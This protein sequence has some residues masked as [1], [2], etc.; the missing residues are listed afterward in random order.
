MNFTIYGVNSNNKG[1]ELM[2]YS[3]KQKIQD[4]DRSNTL[5]TNVK[6]GSLEQGKQVTINYLPTRK[7]QKLAANLIPKTVRKK[8]GIT[9]E[10]EVDAVLDASG[11]A[12]S[13]QW[14]AGKTEH[15]AD[16]YSRWKSQGKKIVLL[17]Q[18][19]GPFTSKRIQDAFSQ[20]LNNVDLVFA[21][22]EVSYE[23]I[24]QLSVPMEQV[25]IAPDFTNLVQ[26]IEPS[27]I[28]DLIG[29]PCIIPNIRMTDK[30][31]P[32]LSR[33]YFSFL[34]SSIEYLLDKGLEPFILLHQLTDFELGSQLQ[35]QVSRTVP[36]IKED[37]PLYIKGILGKCYLVIS[38]RFH[39]L[40]SALSQGVPCVGTGWSHKYKML[41]KTYNCSDLL[42]NLENN[43]DENLSKL[44]AIIYEPTRTQVI[45]AIA[46]AAKQQ[47]VSSQQMWADVE[48]LL[49]NN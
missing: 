4:W 8:Y 11:F 42:I 48:N 22:D 44:D 25:K 7:S 26:G 14:G 38:S 27:Y 6:L 15:M 34:T 21:R 12:Y 47:K 49:V 1:A 29:K 46:Q 28:K 41:F 13:D 35:A 37:N 20:L 2:L 10:S 32:E 16:I 23:C 17:P 39:G 36:V 3:V 19:F 24:S 31:S 40:I 18:A 5:S 45:E 9:L 43:I 30:T 33:S